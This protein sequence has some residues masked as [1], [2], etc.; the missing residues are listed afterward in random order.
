MVS[1]RD[2]VADEIIFTEEPLVIGP[3]FVSPD[4][5]CLGC[6]KSLASVAS[7]PKC[8]KCLWPLCDTQCSEINKFHEFECDFLASGKNSIKDEYR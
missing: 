6:C 4:P 5:V 3:R 2:I 8:P 7:S 1:S